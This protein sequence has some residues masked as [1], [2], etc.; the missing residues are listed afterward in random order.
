VFVDDKFGETRNGEREDNSKELQYQ[1][2]IRLVRL[3]NMALGGYLCHFYST[4]DETVLQSKK[5]SFTIPKLINQSSHGDQITYFVTFPLPTPK[6]LDGENKPSASIISNQPKS[7]V[8]SNSS[9]LTPK[10]NM[11]RQVNQNVNIPALIH[12]S[13][14][15]SQPNSQD[16]ITLEMTVICVN[17]NRIADIEAFWIESCKT[18][19]DMANSPFVQLSQ[20]ALYCL[21]V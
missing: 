7:L 5:S 1:S 13:L 19:S 14:K 4:T 8:T 15:P 6:K 9:S 12:Q 16:N 18:F 21:E 17:F 20:H 2:M 11:S 3:T 10:K